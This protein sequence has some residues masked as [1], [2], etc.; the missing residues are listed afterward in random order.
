MEPIEQ[1]GKNVDDAVAQG[2]MRLGLTPNDVEVE[3]LDEGASGVLGFI[4]TRPARMRIIP[5]S[6]A[7]TV[8]EKMENLLK[9]MKISF[10]LG[11]E[12]RD[13]ICFVQIDTAGAD[14]LLIGR[15]GDTLNALQHL[16]DRMVNRGRSERVR[17]SI[18]V[19]GYRRRRDDSLRQRAMMLAR[20]VKS[21]G[22]ERSTD[23]LIAPERRVVHLA[24]TDDPEV[25]TYTVGEGT[26]RSVVVAPSD[27]RSGGDGPRRRGN[28]NSR[29]RGG[30]A[31]ARG[32]GQP[33]REKVWSGRQ[34]HNSRGNE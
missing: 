30:E 31:D 27:S 32:G 13:E 29:R 12:Y 24:L 5:L 14:G 6:I 23:P 8:R 20:Q 21:T 18:D 16:M 22:R 17:I 4:G 2:L 10:Q 7:D 9:A 33:T 26:Y 19:G 3:V 28:G 15:R 34:N 25:R 11:V 1:Q